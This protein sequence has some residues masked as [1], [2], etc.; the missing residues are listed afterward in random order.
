M[1]NVKLRSG[2]TTM[3]K[4]R[5]TKKGY[6]WLSKAV[7]FVR[8]SFKSVKI[9]LSM[10]NGETGIGFLGLLSIVFVTAKLFGM[11]GWSWAFC[12]A[13]VWVPIVVVIGLAVI[14]AIVASLK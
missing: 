14:A 4:R 6:S 1:K 2:D 8:S 11:V 5:K 12:F 7:S 13:P 3:S 9:K 10:E